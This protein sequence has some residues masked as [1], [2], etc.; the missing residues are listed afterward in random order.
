VTA[1]V[2]GFYFDYASPFAY[3]GSTQLAGISARSGATI[4]LRPML[5]GA[6]FK[7]IGT[8]M[9]PLFAM[10]AAK[11]RMMSFELHRWA[12]HFGVPFRFASRFPQNTVKALRMTLGAPIDKRAALVAALF[13]TIWVGDGDL[14]SDADLRVVASGVGLDPEEALGWTC[15]EPMKSALREATDAAVRAGV[16]GAPTFEVGGEL[17]W[18]QDRIELVEAALQ[19]QLR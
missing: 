6:V 12:D 5:L 16:F 10:P 18:G 15:S 4:D 19:Q 17:Y 7:A 13:R 14:A 8:P 1:P 9:V 2:V 3:L 11:Q